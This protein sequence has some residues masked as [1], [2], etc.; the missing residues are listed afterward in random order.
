MEIE[1]PAE[2]PQ[3]KNDRKYF[4]NSMTVM[5]P[6]DPFPATVAKLD[7]YLT[8]PKTTLG[9][10]TLDLEDGSTLKGA[11]ESPTQYEVGA[12]GVWQ[13]YIKDGMYFLG[14]DLIPAVAKAKKRKA[15]EE[16]A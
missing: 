15:K 2:V 14:M 4:V 8:A 1:I 7:P 13:S 5:V 10:L 3:Q 9:F 6:N 16:Q 12:V 11:T